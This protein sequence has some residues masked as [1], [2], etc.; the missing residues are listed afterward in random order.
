MYEPRRISSICVAPSGQVWAG[1]PS[2]GVFELPAS[3]GDSLFLQTNRALFPELEYVQVIQPA[4]DG[5]VWLGNAEG[6][7]RINGSRT[8]QRIEGLS[9][10]DIRAVLEDRQGNLWIGTA[11]RGLNW[12][13]R[14]GVRVFTSREGLFDDR[15][16]AL[17]ESEDGTLWIGTD[18]GLCRLR[19]G[20]F[21]SLPTDSGVPQHAIQRILE[22]DFG[23]LWLGH[24]AGICRVDRKELDAWILNRSRLPA[25]AEFGTADGILNGEGSDGSQPSAVKGSDGRLWFPTRGGL[26]VVDPAQ[27][28]GNVPA[29]QVLIEGV[30]VDGE[31]LP[32]GA[33]L[34][35]PPGR[36]RHLDIQF[37]ATSLHSPERVRIQYQLEGH[38]SI[39]RDSGSVRLATYAN[40]RPGQYQFRVRA[41]NHEGRWSERDTVFSVRI[42]PHFWQTWPF[43][44]AAASAVLGVAA[45]LVTWRLQQQ[46]RRLEA[47]RLHALEL[48]RRRIA[49]DMHDHLGAQLAGI[50]LASGANESAHQRVRE[51][52]RELND[53]I[54]SV[55][56]DNDTLPS[57]ADFIA[58][59][60]SRYL[61]A[62]CIE[63]DL[64][65]PEQIPSTPI[66]SRLRHEL[67]AMFKEALRNVTQHA[68]AKRV[69]V[70][71][72][73]DRNCLELSI[74]DDGCGFNT[75]GRGLWSARTGNSHA[76][77]P[78][79]L[80]NGLNNF[81]TRSESLGGKC[82]LRS[83]LGDGTEVEFIVPLERATSDLK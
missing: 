58:N 66:P 20:R 47:K 49:R 50:A 67:A 34:T 78:S 72:R 39:W 24:A 61:S 53:L 69:V 76:T 33:S 81:H 30:V 62:A 55:H 25:V 57:L 10:S 63:L 6:L 64:D 46:R 26:A 14:E 68:R 19:D 16:G 83:A 42:E 32:A 56:P 5:S 31:T 15:V 28:S 51:S 13:G 2:G 9:G 21:D 48:E 29:P 79:P 45:G 38:D 43:Q 17:H 8:L 77:P 54:W 27:C 35:L 74:R 82:R 36:G 23:R 11:S 18:A 65:L 3:I 40:L 71:L 52:L 4:R 60:A 12:V 44:V 75:E 41:R 59:F 1:F 80:G 22:D 37:T 70:R 7:Y 73:M